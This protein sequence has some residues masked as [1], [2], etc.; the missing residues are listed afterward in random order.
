M[1]REHMT[2]NTDNGCTAN[3]KRR[4]SQITWVPLLLI[5]LFVVV[6][7]VRL[8]DVPLERDEGEYAY[9]GQL[10]LDG[11]MPYARVYNMKMPGIYFAY[12]AIEAVFG[13]TCRGIRI[14]AIVLNVATILMF[15]FSQETYLGRSL[16]WLR[17]RRLGFFR[18][19][20]QSRG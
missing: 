11:V 16:G 7:R 9:A 15:F 12:A 20:H 6:V 13:Q 3:Q 19:A 2:N 17:L 14:G 4:L 18:L 10:I 1:P 8:L 5:V